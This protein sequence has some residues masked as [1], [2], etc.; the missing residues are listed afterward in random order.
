MKTYFNYESLV[1]S[2]GAAEAIA[3]PIGIGPFCGFGRAVRSGTSITIYPE[4]LDGNTLKFPIKDQIRSRR[5]AKEDDNPETTF[6]VIASDGTVYTDNAPSI[7]INTIQ[8]NSG[9]VNNDIIVFAVHTPIKEPVDNPVSFVAYYNSSA[10]SFYELYKKALDPYYPRSSQGTSYFKNMNILEDENLTYETLC[11]QVELAC[12]GQVNWDT[13]VLVG[14]YGT[15]N[16]AETQTVEDYALV[17]YMGKFP[18]PLN[19]NTAFA[20]VQR[21]QSSILETMLANIPSNISLLE[22]LKDYIQSLL[23]S[24]DTDVG[25]PSGVIVLWSGTTAPSGWAICDGQNGTPDLRGVFVIGAGINND[26]YGS[27]DINSRGGSPSVKLV[28]DQLPQHKHPFQDAYLFE[29]MPISDRSDKIPGT[30]QIDVQGTYY[31]DGKSDVNNRYLF[32]YTHD[33]ENFPV[34]ASTQKAVDII[35]PYVALNYIIKL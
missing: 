20:S 30:T 26:G 14:I 6:G 32:C 4:G 19:Y 1:S 15:G 24:E 21:E 2:R 13:M 3:S 31:G 23:K 28:A 8:G 5:I 34:D 33:T 17:P 9:G 35:P 11:K 18:M 12:D 22:Y 25:I 16:N 27:Y 7:V 10:T 29:S